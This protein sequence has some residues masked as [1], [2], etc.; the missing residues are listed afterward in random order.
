MGFDLA[1]TGSDWSR[2]CISKYS[3]QYQHPRMTWEVAD[4]T[5]LPYDGKQ[6]DVAVNIHTE[7][8]ARS[9]LTDGALR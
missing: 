8:A 3:T 7:S 1:V 9:G 5:A 2:H 6:F 4:A